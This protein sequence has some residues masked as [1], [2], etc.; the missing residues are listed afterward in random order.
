MN[1]IVAE[2]CAG[3]VVPVGGVP[4]FGAHF[5]SVCVNLLKS[6]MRILV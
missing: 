5:I 6:R 2:K 3:C 1:D 4:S